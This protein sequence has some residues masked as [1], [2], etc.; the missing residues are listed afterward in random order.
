[1][2]AFGNTDRGKVRSSNQDS[3]ACG[4]FDDGA[5]WAV[6]CDG[7]GGVTGGDIA[8]RCAV[9]TVKTMLLD[10]YK[11][12]YNGKHFKKL[13]AEA[14]SAANTAIYTKSKE[15]PELAG[16]GTTIVIA[17][18]RKGSLFIAHA[19]DSRAYIIETEARQIT[20]D[21]SV[22][23]ELV[24]RGRLTPEEAL[25]HPHRNIITR[26]LGV[27]RDIAADFE[28]YQLSSG[29]RVLLCSD[30]LTNCVSDTKLAEIS[31]KTSAQALPDEYIAEANANGGYDNITAV[32]ICEE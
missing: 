27:G 13:F 23:Q 22:V 12:R 8:S 29:S 32:I 26:A 16:M 15:Q 21:H 25:A 19:G 11:T 24:D 6:L 9:D 7:M 5:A 2:I 14:V 10:Q 4:V 28:T 17:I 3:F 31:G 1:M 20:K 30:G 18:A